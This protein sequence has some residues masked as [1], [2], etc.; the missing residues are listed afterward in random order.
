M[1]WVRLTGAV[2]GAADGSCRQK[3]LLTLTFK[4]PGAYLIH[5]LPAVAQK[6]H[7]VLSQATARLYTKIVAHKCSCIEMVELQALFPS[8]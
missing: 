4:D 1:V 3:W 5:L 2:A 8:T 6:H 7:L